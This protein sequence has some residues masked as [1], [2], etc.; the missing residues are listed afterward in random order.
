M[1]YSNTFA[2]SFKT[3]LKMKKLFILFAISGLM[4]ASSCGKKDATEVETMVEETTE[5]IEESV[6][7]VEEVADDVVD[8]TEETVEEVV[9]KVEEVVE[10]KN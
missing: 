3:L 6:E 8:T 5:T 9:E 2:R 10:E 7:T 1:K 4:V